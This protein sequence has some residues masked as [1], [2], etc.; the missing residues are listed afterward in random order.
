VGDDQAQHVELTRDLAA[1]FNKQFARKKPIFP[2]PRHV[3][4]KSALG[5]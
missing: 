3:M 2:I 5:P 1:L 4:S